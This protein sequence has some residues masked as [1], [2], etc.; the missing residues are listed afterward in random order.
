MNKDILHQLFRALILLGVIIS[1]GY[2]FKF[3]LLYLYPFLLA[4]MLSL[5]I[6]PIV[7]LMERRLLMPRSLATFSVI[8]LLF[9]SLFGIIIIGISELIQGTSYLSEQLPTYFQLMVGFIES[10]INNKL[11]PIYQH[12]TSLINHLNEKQQATISEYVHL[13][14]KQLG[15]AGGSLLEHLLRAI[16]NF[17]TSLPMSITVFLIVMI[18]TFLITND[19]DYLK[20]V[21]KKITP[22]RATRAG[23]NV[24]YHFKRSLIGYIKAQL[25][26]ITISF[27]IMFIGLIILNVQ[28]ALTIAFLTSLIDIFPYIGIGTVFIPWIIYSFITGNHMLTIGLSIIYM[29]ITIIRQL[30]EPKILA[31]HVGVHPLSALIILFI[32]FQIWGVFGLFVAPLLLILISALY[33][34][35]TIKQIWQFIRG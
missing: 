7:S 24:W 33:Q 35:G 17:F 2:I 6:L 34:S 29:F 27:I 26:L 25:T 22:I 3:I 11:L 14:G 13:Y 30:L 18:A 32:C 20:Q 9:I 21:T 4:L 8:F 1:I 31:I 10:F 16:T 5:F 23:S 19:F 12:L 15:A 28:H